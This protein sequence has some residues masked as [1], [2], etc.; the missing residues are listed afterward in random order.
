MVGTGV[1]ILLSS[2]LPNV[3]RFAV[4]MA[5]ALGLTAVSIGYSYWLYRNLNVRES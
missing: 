4:I 3:W 2:P 5:S 1:L